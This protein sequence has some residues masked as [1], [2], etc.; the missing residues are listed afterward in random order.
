M[1]IRCSSCHKPFAMSKEAVHEALDVLTEGDM[2]HYNASCP[3]CRKTN[4]VSREELLH[5]APGWT[6]GGAEAEEEA[7]T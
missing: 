7:Q 3:H 6:I 2:A 1:Q 5:A 4:K